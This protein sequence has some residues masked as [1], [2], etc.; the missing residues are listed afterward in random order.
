VNLAS[1][2][3]AA[4]GRH[5]APEADAST[6]LP[7]PRAAA[8]VAVPP[9]TDALTRL[10]DRVAKALFER[11]GNRMNDPSLSEEALRSIVL[12]ELDEV[13]ALLYGGHERLAYRRV[14]RPRAQRAFE[15]R[16]DDRQR[17][18][19]L[20]ARVGD[21]AAFAL[22][23]ATQAFEHPVEGFAEASNLIAGL[24]QRQEFVAAGERDLAGTPA[25]SL[26]RPQP[27][28]GQ[29]VAEERGK[30]DGDRAADRE[31]RHDARERL[32]A[33]LER[34]SDRHHPLV[35]ARSRQDACGVL[36]AVEPALNQHTRAG[37]SL[38]EL[39]G[40]QGVLAKPPGAVD[41]GAVGRQ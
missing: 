21:K 4:Q 7:A 16:L 17:G 18:A 24:G 14:V 40:R 38:L 37:G 26:D 2:L 36:D 30:G 35:R 34:L 1:R 10:K 6:P 20:V 22:E 13:V 11:M 32:V 15:L 39:G 41:D 3:A 5:A 8:P 31:R 33:I 23:R 27:C 19:Q 28:R 29:R 9:P 25:H 12:G